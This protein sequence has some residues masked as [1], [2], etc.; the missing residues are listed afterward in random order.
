MNP[1]LERIL[2]TEDIFSVDAE[3]IEIPEWKITKEDGVTIRSMTGRN[4]A[5]VD[6][7][8]H[9][10]SSGKGMDPDYRVKIV[11]WSLFDAD[12]N[13]IIEDRDV[14]QLREKSGVVLDRLFDIALDVNKIVIKEDEAGN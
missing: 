4:R 7:M 13:R 2:E 11:A 1:I 10:A 9:D 5:R 8:S 12:G 3:P 14:H 6:A